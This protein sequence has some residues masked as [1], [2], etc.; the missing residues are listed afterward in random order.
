MKERFQ[1]RDSTWITWRDVKEF[2]ASV[3]ILWRKSSNRPMEGKESL[4]AKGDR[5]EIIN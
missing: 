4:G 5:Q 3:A 1:T 2:L